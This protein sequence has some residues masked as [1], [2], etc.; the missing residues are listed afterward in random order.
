[1]V[2]LPTHVF[3]RVSGC[4]IPFQETKNPFFR[5]R[6]LYHSGISQ[7]QPSL[8]FFHYESILE[9]PTLMFGR[10]GEISK[11]TDDAFIVNNDISLPFLTSLTIGY[12][13]ISIGLLVFITA[14]FYTKRNRKMLLFFPSF[15]F[16]PEFQ[17]LSFS[18]PL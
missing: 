6:G 14:W 16:Q 9:A 17:A 4:C 2:N 12:I 15:V 10:I 7:F 18:C 3:M 1:M 8:F 11:L 5:L 13:V